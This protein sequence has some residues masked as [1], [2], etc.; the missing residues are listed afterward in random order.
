MKL[1]RK[2]IAREYG[3]SKNFMTPK[4][5]DCGL[6]TDRRAWELSTGRG[7]YDE[8]IWGVSVVDYDPDTGKTTRRTDLSEMYQSQ[9]QAAKHIRDIPK[10][11]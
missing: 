9:R 3:N 4:V 8:R 11:G 6:V 7:F 2:I 1:A 10:G 5:L